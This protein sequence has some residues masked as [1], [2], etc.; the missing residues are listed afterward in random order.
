[1]SDKPVVEVVNAEMSR[2]DDELVVC[3][4]LE[5]TD[6]KISSLIRSAIEINNGKPFTVKENIGYVKYEH[7][8]E[9]GSEELLNF[10][11]A[12]KEKLIIKR[13]NS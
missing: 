3:I 5:M 13:K 11:E 6:E 4:N 9:S 7:I 12:N 10:V 2:I 8:I 1:M